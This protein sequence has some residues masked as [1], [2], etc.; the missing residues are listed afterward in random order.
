MFNSCPD[1]NA[2]KKEEMELT[3]TPHKGG[4]NSWQ[5]DQSSLR[6]KQLRGEAWNI[7]H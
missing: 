3:S 5:K 7:R 6:A 2:Y 4:R 1:L